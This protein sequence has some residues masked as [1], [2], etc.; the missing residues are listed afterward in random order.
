MTELIPDPITRRQPHR[1]TSA[2]PSSSRAAFPPTPHRAKNAA[3]THRRL[4]VQND[5]IVY[6]EIHRADELPIWLD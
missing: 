6:A 5:A 4:T 3:A 2:R 1:W